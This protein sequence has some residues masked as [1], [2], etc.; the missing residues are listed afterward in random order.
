MRQLNI[1]FVLFLIFSACE[2][3]LEINTHKDTYNDDI[4]DITFLGNAFYTT[5]YDLSGNSGSQ[6]DLLKF[7][8]DGN[9]LEDAFDL[10]MN[11]QGYLAITNDGRD[12][13]MQ[14]RDFGWVIKCSPVGEL[15][16]IKPDSLS[17]NWRAGGI[18]YREDLDSLAL[19]YQNIDAPEQVRIRIVSKVDPVMGERDTVV[20]F[21]FL[22]ESIGLYAVEYYNSV[23]YLLGVDTTGSDILFQTTREMNIIGRFKIAD[24]TVVGVCKTNNNL[25]LS[26]RDRSIKAWTL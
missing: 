13:Y 5:N 18:C 14:A 4:A 7:T 19:F 12:I 9:C 16:Y 17:A 1:I 25:Y 23:Y 3:D 2:N 10:G 15:V 24:S 11:G 21:G 26:Y 8:S 22:D 6:I 20:Q